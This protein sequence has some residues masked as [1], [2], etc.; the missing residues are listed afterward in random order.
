VLVL[1]ANVGT[2]RLAGE[3]LRVATAGGIRVAVFTI[4]G[5]IVVTLL[6]TLALR[7]GAHHDRT[8]RPQ[9]PAGQ[10]GR[11][12]ERNWFTRAGSR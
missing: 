2:R 3:E 1:V 7:A 10:A 9:K 4:A 8:P 11:R 6:V 5:A 12:M